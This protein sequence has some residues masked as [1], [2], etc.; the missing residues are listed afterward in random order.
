MVV[1]KKKKKKGQIFSKK[2]KQQQVS[3][4]EVKAKGGG[5]NAGLGSHF[6]RVCHCKVFEGPI[7]S[8]SGS[9][10]FWEMTKEGCLN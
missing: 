9:G 4:A 3:D 5:V 8:H 1:K 10:A 7:Q 2:T 6:D